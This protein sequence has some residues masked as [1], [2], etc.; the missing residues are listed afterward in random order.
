MIPRSSLPYVLARLRSPIHLLQCPHWASHQAPEVS[1]AHGHPGT[2][3][4]PVSYAFPAGDK[5]YTCW[6]L[7]FRQYSFNHI[8]RVPQHPA[9]A[10]GHGHCF[11][12]M[13]S[14]PAAFQLP[15]K[16]SD[17][18]ISSEFLPAK[19][20][21]QQGASRRSHL[22]VHVD[23]RDALIQHL[24]LRGHLLQRHSCGQGQ[25]TPPA[26]A[27]DQYR[28]LT[29]AHAAATGVTRHGAPAPNLVTASNGPSATGD[30]ER[31]ASTTMHLPLR[32]AIAWPR[33]RPQ[34]PATL[35]GQRR[36]GPSCRIP[37]QRHAVANEFLDDIGTGVFRRFRD[38]PGGYPLTGQ[39][40]SGM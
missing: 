36:R 11:P 35:T 7:G 27:P 17:P 26:R 21:I 12:G 23:P 16:P 28:R 38:E 2:G 13:L 1:P 34:P 37:R 18:G 8:A 40:V 32:P 4:A 39:V 5:V 9:P 19:P 30:D 15:G 20:G 24:H 29:H 3:L 10:H 14:S 6:R 22:L 31:H 25:G 33:Q